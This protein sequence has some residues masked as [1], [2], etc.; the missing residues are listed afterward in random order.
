MM[1]NRSPHRRECLSGASG[2]FS[3]VRFLGPDQDRPERHSRLTICRSSVHDRLCVPASLCH[4]ITKDLIAPSA[5]SWSLV[6]INPSGPTVLCRHP[7]STVFQHSQFPLVDLTDA[8][9]KKHTFCAPNHTDPQKRSMRFLAR[10]YE[11]PAAPYSAFLTSA[12]P[13]HSLALRSRYF[14]GS[15]TLNL[16]SF[17]P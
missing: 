15:L 6:A 17:L 2:H 5:L 13:D 7:R 4:P 3:L 12:Y 11:L 10:E 8:E 16:G 14:Q 9:G 1:K